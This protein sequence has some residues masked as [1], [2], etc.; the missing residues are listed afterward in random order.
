[1]KNQSII[2]NL[3]AVLCL[4]TINPVQAQNQALMELL[5]AL[6][7]NGTIDKQTYE[8]VKNVAQSES[9]N[10]KKVVQEITREEV[11][12]SVDKAAEKAVKEKVELASNELAKKKKEESENSIRIGGRIQI[13]AATYNGD[14]AGH[15]DGTE[16]RQARLF[17]QGNLGKA[18]GYKLQY[19]FS[20]D[21]VIDGLR[22]AYL[23][24]KGFESFK[25]RVGHTK[26][27]FSLQNMT[28]SKY[29]LFTERALPIVFSRGRNLGLQI[30]HNDKNWSA[31]A[32]VYGRGVNGAQ[33]DN[34]EGYGVS[35]RV[36][37]APINEENRVLHLG[38]TAA[39]RSTGS[40]DALRF[41]VRPESHLTNTRL[42][43]TGTFDA[44]SYNRFVGEAAFISGPFHMQGEYYH[45]SVDREIST[46]EDLD[47][48]GFYV[49]GG[50]FLTGE[51]MNYKP[52]KGIYRR[53]TPKGIV[54]KGGIGAWQVA[55]RYSSLDLTDEDIIG[56]EEENFTLGLNWYATS[57]IRFAANY[58]NVLDVD[59]GTNDG[60]E[61][62]SFQIRTQV[63]F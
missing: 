18:W 46:N 29:V 33:L 49:E 44:D 22:D 16:I 5:K 54:G 2:L 28:S 26:E 31:A 45:T 63:E 48:S 43:D 34:D 38:A 40:I 20:D 25:I 59:G 10:Q 60:D 9:E 11:S 36:T 30:S 15:S 56:G 57:N 7:E 3:V 58:V 32:G 52:S 12:H 14:V 50:W 24:Y 17:A 8:L 27:S 55:M 35:S 37:Y 62:E 61:P 41:R 21:I 47:F 42:V 53:V 1:M 13:D 39:Y 19:D 51:S 6:E 23:D 4:C